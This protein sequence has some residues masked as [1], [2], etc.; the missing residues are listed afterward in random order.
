MSSEWAFGI[1][2]WNEILSCLE[3]KTVSEL[4]CFQLFEAF[5]VSITL[6]GIYG[7]Y[8]FLRKVVN[9]YVTLFWKAGM[10]YSLYIFLQKGFGGSF[11]S[12]NHIYEGRRMSRETEV[13]E[14]V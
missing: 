14:I 4:E 6:K 5:E 9:I 12:Q 11:A 7:I 3:K 2:V 1:N 13:R 10:V 8:S